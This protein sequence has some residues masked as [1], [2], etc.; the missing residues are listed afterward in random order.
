MS[1]RR[2]PTRRDRRC[3]TR[4]SRRTR[5]PLTSDLGSLIAGSGER[6]RRRR[7]RRREADAR[8]HRRQ[9]A[10]GHDRVGRQPVDLGLVEQQEERAVAADA[11]VGVVRRRAAPRST[12]ASCSCSTRRAGALAQLLQLAELDRVGRARLGAGRLLPDAEPVVAER[13]LEDAPVVLALVEDAVGARRD[14]VAAAVADVRPARRRCRT[15]CGTSRRS[16]RRRGRRRACSACRRRRTS[17]SGSRR[18][19]RWKFVIVAAERR[20]LLDEGDVAPACRR[21]GRRELSC[22]RPVQFSPSSGT[23]FHSLQA[24]SHAL[25]PMHTEVSVKKPI[26]GGCSRVAGACRPGRRLAQQTLSRCR[27]TRSRR[28]SRLRGDPGALAVLA[29]ERLARRRRAGA[30]P[31]GCRRSAP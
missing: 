4:G 28:H 20:A 7:A 18:P 22:E 2:T 17:A 26:R 24:T 31:G 1:R 10:R 12:P 6:S 16:G 9:V 15:R 5:Q 14:A 21:P 8:P 11:V 23:P 3:R 13:A 27:R 29:D 30:G 25:Q 19:S